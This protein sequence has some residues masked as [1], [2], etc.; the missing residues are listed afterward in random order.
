MLAVVDES[1]MPRGDDLVERGLVVAESC[2]DNEARQPVRVGL[3]VGSAAGGSEML[4]LQS[5]LMFN[6]IQSR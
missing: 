6:Q 5:S 3:Q 4:G 1:E 2:A